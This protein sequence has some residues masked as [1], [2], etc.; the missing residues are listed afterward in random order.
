[1][2][3]K[4]FKVQRTRISV[5]PP[6][7]QILA[8]QLLSQHIYSL[9]ND[10]SIQSISSMKFLFRLYSLILFLRYIVSN[11]IL[12]YKNSFHKAVWREGGREGRKTKKNLSQQLEKHPR[13][14]I[15]TQIHTNKQT[16]KTTYQSGTSTRRI[17]SFLWGLQETEITVAPFLKFIFKFLLQLQSNHLGSLTFT[18]RILILGMRADKISQSRQSY[19]IF[20]PT[21]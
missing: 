18:F 17:H 9:K 19:Q 7:S 13:S 6:F 14:K 20:T 16:K 1:M 15:K 21:T 4:Y 12:R 3:I 11:F 5:C 10:E 8:P 2:T